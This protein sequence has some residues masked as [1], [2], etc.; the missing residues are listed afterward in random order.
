[1]CSS[2]LDRYPLPLLLDLFDAPKKACVYTKIDLHHA[3]HLVHIADGGEW[4]IT[5]CTRYG[6]YEW[7]LVPFGLTN[8]PA[9]FQRF[10]NDIFHDLLDICVIIYLNNILIYSEDMTQHWAHVKIVLHRLCAN[11]FFASAQKYEF[12]KDTV[13][14][15]GFILSPN[16]L[17]MAQDKVQSILD[18]PEPCKV[19]DVQS[20]L[21]F[22]NFY[23]RFIHG[24]SELTI[25]LTRLTRKHAHWN[26]SDS[27]RMA[28]NHLKEEF[29]HA[30]ILTHWVPDSHMVV[31]TDTSDYA[32]ATILSICTSD[33]EI[34]PMAFHSRSFNS[35]EL[36][37]DTHDKELL[38]IFEA[39]KHWRQYLK[40]STI[41]IDVV[42]DRKNLEYFV[43]TKLLT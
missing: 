22:C 15:L 29:T 42:M 20:F 34:H 12:H 39:F 17:H 21:S 43:T 25:P 16:G 36:N 37:Y 40:G 14:D 23:R 9:T 3:Y 32:L 1:M 2:D 28:F 4:K 26:F 35:A 31:K 19:K 10:M 33:G 5:F 8:A 27:C 30:P 41:S 38:T 24:Y 6:S 13:E 11:S 18:W 7:L